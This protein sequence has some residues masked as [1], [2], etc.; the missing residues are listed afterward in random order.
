[1]ILGAATLFSLALV[2]FSSTQ[3]YLT[4]TIV[5]ADFDSDASRLA[6]ASAET[7]GTLICVWNAANGDGVDVRVVPNAYVA[8]EYSQANDGQLIHTD[9]VRKYLWDFDRNP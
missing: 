1:M 4:S 9:E 3:P 8:V 6:T 5:S 2:P 7:A